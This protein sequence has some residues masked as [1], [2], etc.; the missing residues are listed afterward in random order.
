MT[1]AGRPGTARGPGPTWVSVPVLQGEFRV[2][3]GADVVFTTVLGSC[4]ATC[5]YDRERG[6][7]GMNHFLLAGDERSD[8]ASLRYGI[9]AM[10]LLVNELLKKGARRDRLEAKL[11]GGGQMLGGGH[12][13]G[14]GNARFALWF[15]ENEGI[16]C[17]GQSLGGT[18]P[19]KLR[20]WPRNGQAQ[21]QFVAETAAA[22]PAAT[23][24]PELPVSAPGGITLF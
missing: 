18:R 10:E 2:S 23:P 5:L 17:V 12:G 15:L 14:A 13:I 20:F 9:N 1:P 11:F 4:I 7:G 3:A 19:R 16:R 21:Q 6:V 24:A 8:R 22:L